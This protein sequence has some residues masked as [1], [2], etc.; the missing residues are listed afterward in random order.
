MLENSIQITSD[1][2]IVV[3]HDFLIDRINRLKSIDDRYR[4]QFILGDNAPSL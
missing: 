1:S 4:T 3:M 2:S